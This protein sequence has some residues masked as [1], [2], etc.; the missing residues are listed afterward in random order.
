[1]T[2]HSNTFEIGGQESAA[3]ILESLGLFMFFRGIKI[4]VR[5]RV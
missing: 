4:G 3:I 5:R 1:M 2:V